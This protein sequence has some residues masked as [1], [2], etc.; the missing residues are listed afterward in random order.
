VQIKHVV[1]REILALNRRR[2]SRKGSRATI[3]IF[4]TIIF[5]YARARRTLGTSS[6]AD[7]SVRRHTFLREVKWDTA[8]VKPHRISLLF[9]VQMLSCCFIVLRLFNILLLMLIHCRLAVAPNLI[10]V[11]CKQST[12]HTDHHPGSCN[13]PVAFYLPLTFSEVPSDTEQAPIRQPSD[14]TG[15]N[16]PSTVTGLATDVIEA[17]LHICHLQKQTPVDRTP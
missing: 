11:T 17:K 3:G 16:L 5:G 6:P 2:S 10:W 15:G 1:T 13:A 12:C 8:N 9:S 14:Y 4:A 7:R